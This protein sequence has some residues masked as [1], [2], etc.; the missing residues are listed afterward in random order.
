MSKKRKR[1]VSA[2]AIFMAFLIV[3]GLF[4]SVIGTISA[5]A[6]SQAE[7]DKLEEQKKEIQEE[8]DKLKEELE[9]LETEQT[10]YLEQKAALD[11]QNELARQEI[12]LI[13][14]QIDIY[15]RLIESKAEEV[16]NAIDAEE[17]QMS[18]Y[19]TRVRAMEENG[20]VGYLAILF[21]ATSFSDLLFRIDSIAE[22]MAYDKQ[23][24]EKYIEAR[25]NTQDAKAAYEKTQEEQ[26]E[27]REELEEKKLQLEAE[28]EAACK[29]IAELEN[30]IEEYTKAYEENAAAEAEVQAEIDEMIAELQRR[31]EEERK[32]KEE[33]ERKQQQQQNQSPNSGTTSKPVVSTGSYI[34]PYPQNNYVHSPFGWRIHPIFGDN[35][36]H[37]G[38]DI[39]GAMGQP[40]VAIASGTVVTAVYSSS[41]GN[42]VVINHGNGNTS[43]YAHLNSMAVSVGAKVSQGQTIGYC[44]TTGWSTGPHLHFEITAGGTR[45]D[46]LSYYSSSSYVRGF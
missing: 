17:K 25:E 26:K 44:G 29:I 18:A 8:K 4:A 38:I 39:G 22:I 32:R 30:D 23:L 42:Y 37:S 33:E 19:R 45:V 28:I 46:P 31:E 2:V 41:Y 1:F 15:D 14:E 34:W 20:S 35:R 7:I 36:F 9:A 6:V 11:M 13:D 24:E 43:L 3:L 21:R 5:G 10:S 12:E 40:I 27:V 16:E